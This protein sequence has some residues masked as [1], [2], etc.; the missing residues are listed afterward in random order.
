M[1]TD[2][3]GQQI[4]NYHL[5]KLLGVGGFADIYLG[6]HRYL[7]SDAALK[8]LRKTL[9][10]DDEQQFLAEAQI[11]VRLRHPHIVRVL[12]F[13]VEQGTP[14]LIMEYAPHGTLRDR[15]PPGM[16]LPL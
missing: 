12:D 14:V 13:A 4:G 11:L 9:S 15:Y 8:V 5:V 3:V 10:E 6:Q 16:C 2:R 1:V 7:Q